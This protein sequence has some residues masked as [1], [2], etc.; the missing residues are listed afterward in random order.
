[1][2]HAR[3]FAAMALLCLASCSSDTSPPPDSEVL[4]QLSAG[5]K[6]PCGPT[7]CA[8]GCCSRGTCI[9]PPTAS[10]CGTGGAECVDCAAKGQSCSGG[11]CVA[12]CS[13]EKGCAD[14]TKVCDSGKCVLCK[15]GTFNCD[16]VNDCECT[17]GCVGTQCR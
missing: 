3:V 14:N 17:R 10:K 11:G 16:I 5:D 7:T 12:E 15:S 13:F 9:V 8:K 4:D 1:M 6:T 2:L